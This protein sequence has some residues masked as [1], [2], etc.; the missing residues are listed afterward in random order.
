MT[1]GVSNSRLDMSPAEGEQFYAWCHKS[2]QKPTTEGSI[3]PK[4][5]SLLLC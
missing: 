1:V 2:S 5:T 3:G 4:G